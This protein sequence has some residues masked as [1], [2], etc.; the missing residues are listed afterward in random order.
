MSG[1]AVGLKNITEL[2]VGDMGIKDVIVDDT[3]IYTRQGGHFYLE[4][5]TEEA[6]I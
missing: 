4:L 3:T 6:S 1:I 2:F 5:S